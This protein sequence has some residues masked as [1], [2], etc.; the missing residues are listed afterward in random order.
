MPLR[1]LGICRREDIAMLP[2]DWSGGQPGMPLRGPE[3]TCS[4]P[5]RREIRW[6]ADGPLAAATVPPA[7]ANAGP[8][9]YA[10]WLAALHAHINIL[11]VR[12]GTVLP[13]EEAV[14]QFLGT[15]REDLL[16]D[17]LR[18]A[19]SGE[20]GLRV[21]LADLAT[22]PQNENEERLPA[23]SPGQYLALR[24]QRY[25]WKDRAERQ[26]R[27]AAESF[28]QTMQGLY[29]EW[30]APISPVPTIV[31]LAFLVP[32]DLWGIF[33]ERIEAATPGQAS[34]QCTLL[35]PWPPYSFV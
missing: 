24:R 4:A 25:A 23:I 33:R 5:C 22:P 15:R 17:L 11:P 31:R 13:D 2:A 12:Y 10:A 27:L 28:V 26:A 20:I 9:E 8:L 29:R 35:G 30:R 32:R 19:G 1:L 21:D 6:L 7:P 34:R 3:E 16:R 14:R 18:V